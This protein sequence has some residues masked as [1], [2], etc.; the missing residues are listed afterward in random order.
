MKRIEVSRGE[1]G[2]AVSVAKKKKKKNSP[3]DPSAGLFC[4]WTTVVV[5][6]IINVHR[7][8]YPHVKL[9]ISV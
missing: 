5:T 6:D 2:R 9:L 7:T 3:R 4:V 1:G 8:K